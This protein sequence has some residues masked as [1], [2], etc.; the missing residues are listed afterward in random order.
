M[1]TTDR[2]RALADAA[3]PFGDGEIVHLD[4]DTLRRLI[5]L[6]EGLARATAAYLDEVDASRA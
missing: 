3:T 2:L 5:D 4:P 1:T 6:A